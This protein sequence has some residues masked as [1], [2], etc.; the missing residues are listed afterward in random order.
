[1]G[2][3]KIATDITPKVRAIV[4]RRDNQ[5]CIYCNTPHAIQLA[6]VF[7]SRAHGGLGVPEN[8]VCL[9]IEHH[10]AMDNGKIDKAQP[11][12]DVAK[13]YLKNQYPNINIED[14][15]YKKYDTFK[16]NTEEQ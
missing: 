12:K 5:R 15:K 14:L 6:H 16:L 1:M 4:K 3:Q 7:V 13:F 9:C 11:I 10:M 2:K 8:L